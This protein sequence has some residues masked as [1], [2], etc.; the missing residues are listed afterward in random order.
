[1]V[2]GCNKKTAKTKDTKTGSKS[3]DRFKSKECSL[4]YKNCVKFQII[5]K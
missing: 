4:G 3:N 2:S 5:F 1:M